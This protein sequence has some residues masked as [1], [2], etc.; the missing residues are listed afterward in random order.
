M[1]IPWRR[2]ATSDVRT[3]NIFLASAH[4][5]QGTH[6]QF[7]QG[8]IA[9]I[10]G[11]NNSGKSTFLQEIG[12]GVSSST[13]V[14]RAFT[15]LKY[16]NSDA[17][18]IRRR[19]EEYFQILTEGGSEYAL[20]PENRRIYL[21]RLE[22]GP[23]SLALGEASKA[24]VANLD[25]SRR[26]LL[27]QDVSTFDLLT[28][29]P[30][31]PFHV[32][33]GNNDLLLSFSGSIRLAFNTDF[34][35]TRVGNPVRGYVGS[36]FDRTDSAASDQ[37]NARVGKPLLTQGDGIRS[38]IGILAEITAMSH[39]IVLLDEP[40]AFLHPP[41]ARRL[42]T[43]I[44]ATLEHDRQAFI[45]THSTHFLQGCLKSR[46]ERLRIIRLDCV[47]STYSAK[48][49]SNDV[50]LEAFRLPSIANTNLL[51][52]LFYEQTVICEGDADAS[53][54]SDLTD[55]I[56]E[57]STDRFWFSAGG[58]YQTV[59]V[60]HLLT[61]FGVDW[62]V[63]LDLV[64]ITDWK[65]LSSLASLKGL[66]I[67]PRRLAIL[68]AL[69]VLK[70]VS[71]GDA[72]RLISEAVSSHSND[73][74]ALRAV[75]A[76]LSSRKRTGSLKQHGMSAFNKGQ[77]RVDVKGLL[78][79]LDSVGIC[80]LRSGELESY[81]PSVGKH[82]PGWLEGVRANKTAYERELETLRADISKALLK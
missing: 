24:F 58:K 9:L 10:V 70:P 45:A 5:R 33:I 3:G 41:Q 44:L 57:L 36:E 46:N 27:S 37:N 38:Y 56:S 59:K 80:L 47:G 65:L 32:F 2:G 30:S 76:I 1:R 71:S 8:T 14:S 21:R 73:E 35:I 22:G 34:T 7:E 29:K 53:L 19:L 39:P 54:F 62:R 17:R 82:G 15:K 25:A 79:A 42:A 51:D 72:K 13:E 40:E 48:S 12:L 16:G 4:L 31:H 28:G 81:V 50:A 55:Q 52:S 26:L 6:I 49:I 75:T 61:Q 11:P 64:A 68:S 77:E 63:I 60:A 67:E 74:D 20:E 23:D 69:R 43:T 18:Q 78:D 66:D